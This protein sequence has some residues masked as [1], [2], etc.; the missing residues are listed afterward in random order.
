[1]ENFAKYGLLV[2]VLCILI[3]LSCSESDDASSTPSPPPSNY[4]RAGRKLYDAEL[5][6]GPDPENSP[7]AAE[8]GF[9]IIPRTTAGKKY[10]IPYRH[11]G[12]GVLKK[13]GNNQ[14]WNV[15]KG[16]EEHS[17]EDDESSNDNSPKWQPPP[18]QWDNNA[19][20]ADPMSILLLKNAVADM[21]K[22]TTFLDKITSDPALFLVAA[23]IPLSLLLAA[24][25]PVFMNSFTHTG[26][27]PTITTTAT[28]PS[29]SRSNDLD[30]MPYLTPVMEAIGTFG[31]RSI[32]NPDCMQRIF[33][34]VAQEKVDSNELKYLKKAA[35][36]AKYLSVGTWLENL[37][38]NDIVDSLSSG[39]CENIP[40]GHSA[41]KENAKSKYSPKKS[42][43][44]V[45][46]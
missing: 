20:L 43:D 25:L 28:G 44:S 13:S 10:V 35:N 12:S 42:S 26:S 34:Q 18:Q 1:M 33:C 30:I 27:M 8:S 38:V 32:S 23:V 6:T 29:K 41:K 11:A 2:S 21:N 19:W 45:K 4:D 40:C 31:I 37:G 14:N 9:Q 39:R 22:P 24:V 46:K 16:D 15:W 5:Y 7:F 17:E 36:V 3:N